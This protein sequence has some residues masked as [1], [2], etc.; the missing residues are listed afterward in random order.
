M[1]IEEDDAARDV[2]DAVGGEVEGV[3]VA[4]VEVEVEEVEVVEVKEVEGEVETLGK[5]K[6]ARGIEVGF[7]G[8]RE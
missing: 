4:E 3:E 5:V 1:A 8:G 7:D 2:Y 6:E